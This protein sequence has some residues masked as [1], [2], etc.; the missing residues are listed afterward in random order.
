MYFI[1]SYLHFITSLWGLINNAINKYQIIIKCLHF[2]MRFHS[3][4][5]NIWKRWDSSYCFYYQ[6]AC[7]LWNYWF[8][9]KVDCFTVWVQFHLAD[10]VINRWFQT[11]ESSVGI[12]QRFRYIAHEVKTFCYL[13]L[14]INVPSQLVRDQKKKQYN[15][16]ERIT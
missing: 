6:V 15:V 5:S 12:W 14:F 2:K 10:Q 16:N 1:I 9:N 13:S 11:I 7:S 4:I 3:V 8:R